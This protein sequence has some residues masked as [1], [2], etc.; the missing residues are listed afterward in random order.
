MELGPFFAQL[1]SHDWAYHDLYAHR[2]PVHRTIDGKLFAGILL[3]C[4]GSN[5]A[6]L[7]A[8]KVQLYCDL[9]CGR[10]ILRMLDAHFLQQGSHRQQQVLQ[11]V[12]NSKPD[13][14][15]TLDEFLVQFEQNCSHLRGSPEEISDVLA[16]TL[17][18]TKVAHF[19]KLS[20]TFAQW[21]VFGA[22]SESPLTDLTQGIRTVILEH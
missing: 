12:M 16:C 15:D 5:E 17:L 10:Q 8:D 6:V 21:S 13:S 18:R 20:A 1:D 22:H 9:G 4:K 19:A 2:D 3:A 11:D 7:L 14:F